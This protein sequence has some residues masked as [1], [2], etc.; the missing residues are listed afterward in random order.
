[1]GRKGHQNEKEL[2]LGSSAPKKPRTQWSDILDAVLAPCGSF[3]HGEVV[4]NPLFSTRMLLHSTL[5]ITSNL[6]S[7]IVLSSFVNAH[8]RSNIS[9]S[10]RLLIGHGHEVWKTTRIT[11]FSISKRLRLLGNLFLSHYLAFSEICHSNLYAHH[12]RSDFST[13]F[14]IQIEKYLSN[15]KKNAFAFYNFS[16]YQFSDM[17]NVKRQVVAQKEVAIRVANKEVARRT[18]ERLGKRLINETH[19]LGIQINFIAFEQASE[20]VLERAFVQIVFRASF[21]DLSFDDRFR[22]FESH[23]DEVVSSSL[24]YR[25]STDDKTVS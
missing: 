8:G 16:C 24:I 20:Q 22:T 21:D 9:E 18:D 7:S 3:P 10:F 5:Y 13:S 19:L 2:G 4:D 17:S 6:A 25:S 1:M 12:L 11:N 14:Q 23:F 15:I